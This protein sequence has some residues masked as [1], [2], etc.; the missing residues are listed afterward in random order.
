MCALSYICAMKFMAEIDVMPLP[1]LLDPQGRTV[2]QTMPQLGLDSISEVR[3]GKHISLE[4]EADNQ[5]DASAKVDDACKRLLVN[6][7]MEKY[8]FTI[9]KKA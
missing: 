7:V 9:S 1:G 4:V 8:T 2:S 6:M 3:I 5:D